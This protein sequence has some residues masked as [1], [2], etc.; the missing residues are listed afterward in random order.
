[1]K[2]VCVGHST[3]DTTLPLDE[4]PTEN[5]KYRVNKHICCGGGP[6]SNGGYLLAK[7][8]IDTTMVS[9]VGKDYYGDR[10]VEDFRKIGA[11]TDYLLQYPDHNTS[12]SIIIAKIRIC[13]VFI[14]FIP[15]FSSNAPSPSMGFS[16]ASRSYSS[17]V[18]GGAGS[19][20]STS[21]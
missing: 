5:K 19:M 11:N 3:Y 9:I 16:Y 20:T 4:F 12:S 18:N 21:S 14:E 6:A 13:F 17:F 2:A 7:W 15:V 8:G 1:M 10:I